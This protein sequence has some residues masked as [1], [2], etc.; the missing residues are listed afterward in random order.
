M[1][2]LSDCE[3][4]PESH[5]RNPKISMPTLESH[6]DKAL[7]VVRWMLCRPEMNRGAVPITVMAPAYN[8]PIRD[9]VLPLHHRPSHVL[10]P[11]LLDTKFSATDPIW[12]LATRA[13]DVSV[14][15]QPRRMNRRMS[16]HIDSTNS[17][18]R[19]FRAAYINAAC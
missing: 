8:A 2:E 3:S 4:I 6:Y 1:W 13:R 11:L 18:C 19:L 10:R 12:S 14:I 17:S 16:C 15:A 9:S 5:C 7:R